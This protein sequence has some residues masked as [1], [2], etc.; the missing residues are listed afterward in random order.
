MIRALWL[1]GLL[2]LGVLLFPR[3]VAADA[4]SA[5]E[6][7]P[8]VRLLIDISGSMK[9]SDPLNLRA[10]AVELIVQMLPEGARAGIWIFGEG[11]SPLVDHGEVDKAWR[12][13][14]E[15]AIK[16]IDNTPFLGQVVRVGFAFEK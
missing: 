12:D 9:D 16:A 14:A 6:L 15:R 13:E 5:V 3:F 1:H 11:V 7:K 8:D 10:P 4:A 2:C